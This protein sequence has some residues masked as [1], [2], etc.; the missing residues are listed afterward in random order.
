MKFYSLAFAFDE[1]FERVV[2]IRKNRPEWQK[3][4]LNGVGGKI[5]EGELPSQAAM[6]EFR[7]ETG[8]DYPDWRYVGNLHGSDYV[9]YV[10]SARCDGI[11]ENIKST[12]D[13]DVFVVPVN[14]LGGVISNLKW[15]I[16]FAIDSFDN[17]QTFDVLYVD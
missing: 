12:T 11:I 13:E 8:V 10:F 15:M 2:L 5:E 14:K 4:K 17:H 16:P 7:E 9:V 6:R 1:K 3:G